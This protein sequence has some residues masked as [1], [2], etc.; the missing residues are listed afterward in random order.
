MVSL[1]D[2]LQREFLDMLQRQHPENKEFEDDL[3]HIRRKVGS[4]ETPA[5]KELRL[6][7]EHRVNLFVLE[8][9]ERI[10]HGDLLQGGVKMVYIATAWGG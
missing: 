5:D 9:G 6:Q 4:D 7:A 2:D 3:E 10:G 8:K 1:C